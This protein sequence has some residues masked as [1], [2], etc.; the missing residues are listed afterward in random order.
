MPKKIKKKDVDKMV[1][2]TGLPS[3]VC[4]VYLRRPDLQKA[5]PNPKIGLM[6]W[7]RKH[8]VKEEPKLSK[9]LSR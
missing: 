4:R 9:L 1:E 3:E 6:D 8:G 2:E 5:F 7:V